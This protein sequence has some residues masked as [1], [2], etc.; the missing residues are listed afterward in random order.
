[1]GLDI[2]A[3]GRCT[4]IGVTFDA[5]GEVEQP[6]TVKPYVNPDFPAQA[7]GI[8]SNIWYQYETCMTFG[9]GSYPSYGAWRRELAKIGGYDQKD[10]WEGRIAEGPFVELVNFADNEGVLGPE[11]SAKLARDFEDRMERARNMMDGDDFRLYG[12]WLKALTMAA[13]GGL[14]NFR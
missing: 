10:V 2:N 1:M 5:H 8:I 14:I 13:D 7:D 11:T 9:A 4:P 12:K 3:Y 6:R